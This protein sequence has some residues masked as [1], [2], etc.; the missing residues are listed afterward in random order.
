MTYWNYRVI[1][2]KKYGYGVH[3][4]YYNKAGKPDSWAVE[5]D[6]WAETLKELKSML[7]DMLKGMDKHP[8]L[9][10]KN[11]KLTKKS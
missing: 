1:K 6:V 10:I 11:E 3:E 5:P 8:V 9:V 4:V 7:K 2:S